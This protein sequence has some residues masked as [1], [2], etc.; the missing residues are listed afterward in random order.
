MN[1]VVVGTGYVG[2]ISGVCLAAKG[3]RV[4]CVDVDP[5]VVSKLNSGAPHIYER[6][7]EPLLCEVLAE[8]RFSATCDL[9]VAL[10]TAELALIAV[11][12]PSVNDVIDLR[13]IRQVA[14]DIGT[15][16]K[17]CDRHL[18]IVV[19]STVVPGTTDT[20]VRKEIEAASDKSWP[21][22]GLGMNPEFLR[23]GDAIEDFMEPD[24]II[25]G[26][27]DARTLERLEAL[28]APWNCDKVRV[29]T[30]TAEMIKY[31][32]NVL[33]ATQISAANE[34]ANLSAAVGEIDA[35]DVMRGVHLDKRWSP[36]TGNGRVFPVILT[37]LVPG[38]GFGGSC[39]PKDVQALRSLGEQYGLK[40]DMLNAVL[41]V[42]D[43][44][45]GQVTII[46]KRRLGDLGGRRCLV[47]GLAFKPGTDDVRESSSLKIVTNLIAEGADVAAHDPVA[48]DNFRRALGELAAQVVFVED[49]RSCLKDAEVLI[50]ATKW[51]E[52]KE[53]EGWDLGGKIVIDA[54]RLLEPTALKGADYLSIG[55]RLS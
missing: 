36:I 17:T 49:W 37:Y 15:Y 30:R 35:L 12:T 38:C 14:R 4:A 25:L 50:V 18:S 54:R 1:I 9:A 19:K 42:N 51:D 13:Y 52:Y 20:V 21:E 29:N 3:H 10:D 34:I 24:R 8:K 41:A 39:F 28:Y 22:F 16:L 44:Q 23:E 32:N 53:L 45:P 48:T 46:L 11:G 47:L 7:L 43:A 26:H 33:L 40:M 55:R 27:E 2:L 5:A 6:G 31:A